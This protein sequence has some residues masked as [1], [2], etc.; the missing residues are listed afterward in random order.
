MFLEFVLVPLPFNPAN[1]GDIHLMMSFPFL[2]LSVT[3]I[4]TVLCQK[5]DCI[6]CHP[7]IRE[8][9]LVSIC[10]NK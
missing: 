5:S 9:T 4:L 6:Y 2:A 8:N 10:F 7:A 1:I 3:H